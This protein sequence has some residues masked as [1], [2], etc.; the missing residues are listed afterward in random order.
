MTARDTLVAA[1][2]KNRLCRP[3][4]D[5]LLVGVGEVGADFDV[6][7]LSEDDD[8]TSTL[9]SRVCALLESSGLSPV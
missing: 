4:F 6:C 8:A 1:L 3:P 9:R 2:S 7:L 5:S